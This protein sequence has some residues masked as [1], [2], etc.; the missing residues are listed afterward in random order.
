MRLLHTAWVVIEEPK[1][2]CKGLVIPHRCDCEKKKEKK[3]PHASS[4]RRVATEMSLDPLRSDAEWLDEAKTV[5]C[6]LFISP[7]L[8]RPGGTLGHGAGCLS[9]PV[10]YFTCDDGVGWGLK[11]WISRTRNGRY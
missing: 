8:L 7:S 10:V 2:K 3:N 6:I 11:R 9:A 4:L 1:A 5:D